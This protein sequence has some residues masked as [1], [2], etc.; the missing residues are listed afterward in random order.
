VV[1]RIDNDPITAADLDR[2]LAELGPMVRARYTSPPD[3]RKLLDA[4]VDR[5]VLAREARS[6]GYDKR[7]EIQ[8]MVDDYVSAALLRDEVDSK[9][10]PE[11]VPAA[12]VER[13]FR[14]HEQEFSR[15]EEVRASVV[16]LRDRTKA[17]QV[18][19][20]ARKGSVTDDRPFRLLVARHS[21]DPE[22][23]NRGGDLGFFDRRTTR[24]PHSV[25]DAAFALEKIGDISSPVQGERGFY[26]V[27]LDQRRPGFSRSLADVREQI[28]R[29]LL[30]EVRA[31]RVAEL[32][33][34]ARSQHQVQTFD[35]ALAQVKP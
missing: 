1:A 22:T 13:Y 28:R 17:E 19:A 21:Q 2:R 29:Q 18:A 26:V 34:R 27:R 25:V 16:V 4:V 7:P 3:R 33:G 5:E 30:T 10:K 20:E 8:K 9:L 32:V 6:R 35:Q 31:R 14:E 23:K 15:P 12:D 11:D 24:Y